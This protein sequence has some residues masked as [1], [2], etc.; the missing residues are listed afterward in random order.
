MLVLGFVTNHLNMSGD[1]GVMPVNP[2]NG[3]P[4]VKGAS[5]QTAVSTW[6]NQDLRLKH[7]EAGFECHRIRKL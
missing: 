6:L 7:S 1:G 2:F 3:K 5:Q 4:F